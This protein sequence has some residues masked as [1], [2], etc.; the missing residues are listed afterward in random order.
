MKITEDQK[1]I[2]LAGV[3]VGA[4]RMGNKAFDALDKATKSAKTEDQ[5]MIL[6][7][8]GSDIPNEEAIVVEIA[9]EIDKFGHISIPDNGN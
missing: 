1:Q 6:L 2:F 9:K 7:P 8:I 4:N 5:L 3:L